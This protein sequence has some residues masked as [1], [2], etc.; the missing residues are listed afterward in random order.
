LKFGTFTVDIIDD[1]R[2]LPAA[3]FKQTTSKFFDGEIL[4]RQALLD[5]NHED[6]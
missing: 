4:H 3:L 5:D 1:A 2:T 6:L